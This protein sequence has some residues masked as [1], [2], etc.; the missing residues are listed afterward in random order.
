MGLM[1][2]R[3][4]LSDVLTRAFAVSTAL[5]LIVILTGCAGEPSAA[6]PVETAPTPGGAI[7]IFTADTPP[8]EAPAEP[9]EAA[10]PTADEPALTGE[11]IVEGQVAMGSPTSSFAP[12]GIQVTLRGQTL[13]MMTGALETSLTLTATTDANGNFRFEGVP[14]D[15]PH[16]FYEVSA[17]HNGIVFSEWAMADPASTALSIPLTIYESTD[18]PAAI[19][20]DAMHTIIRRYRDA[21][22][23]F[24]LYV[25][26]NSSDRIYISPTA[27]GDGRRASV[28]VLLPPNAQDVVFEED[29]LGTRFVAVGSGV[30]DTEYVLPGQQSHVVSFSYILPPDTR[31]IALPITYATARV[32]VLAEPG[33]RVRSPALTAAG[34]QT[35]EDVSYNAY[36][37]ADLAPGETLSLRIRAPGEGDSTA[38]IVLGVGAA[39]AIVGSGAYWGIRRRTRAVGL[40]ARQ[41]AL[42][43]QIAELDEAFEAERINRL[44]YEA[45]R[46][47]LKAALAEEFQND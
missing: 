27:V 34:T 7:Q 8:A 33:I 16:L 24:Q 40:T 30:Y 3:L 37:G 6:G 13:N 36:T 31:E 18:N 17:E 45:R 25:Y 29:E 22:L 44:D 4:R 43:R 11:G 14:M 39:L 42:I 26:S 9:A 32:N 47:D 35:I 10:E 12:V 15:Q 20:V 21:L 2:K 38:L 1:V 23:V 41:G 28:S 46:A 5:S 19:T